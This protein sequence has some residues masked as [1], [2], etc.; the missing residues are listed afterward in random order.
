[1]YFVDHVAI[2]HMTRRDRIV[3]GVVMIGIDIG[4]NTELGAA[5]LSRGKM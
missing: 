2:L 4:L 5:S 1:M 3:K